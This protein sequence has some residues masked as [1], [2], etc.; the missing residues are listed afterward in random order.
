MADALSIGASR[1]WNP[2]PK[3]F[4]VATYAMALHSRRDTSVD[5]SDNGDAVAISDRPGIGDCW[6]AWS[7]VSFIRMDESPRK[8]NLLMRFQRHLAEMT[9]VIAG[10]CIMTFTASQIWQGY[11]FG[12]SANTSRTQDIVTFHLLHAV[13][14]GVA[15]C[16]LTVSVV[17]ARHLLLRYKQSAKT[18]GR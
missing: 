6:Q 8:S 16:A 13:M 11:A 5:A 7:G 18:V 9:V 15:L 12:E 14:I 1:C 10:P 17:I 2:E 3:N 4:I